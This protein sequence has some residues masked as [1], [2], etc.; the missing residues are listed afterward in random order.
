MVLKKIGSAIG[1]VLRIDSYPVSG[2][3]RSYA[4]LCIQVDLDKPLI[5]IVKIGRLR[6]KVMY[7]GISS[8]CFCCRCI[9]HKNENCCYEIQPKKV[10][11][12][13]EEIMP[14]SPKES[15]VEDMNKTIAILEKM[16]AQ[17]RVAPTDT[18]GWFKDELCATWKHIFPIMLSRNKTENL[19]LDHLAWGLT[20]DPRWKFLTDI[21]LITEK[22]LEELNKQR[23]PLIVPHLDKLGWLVQE[24][25]VIDFRG[26]VASHMGNMP[27]MKLF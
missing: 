23:R 2:S 20:L 9:G 4:R 6:Q 25:K 8:L 19:P 16:I 24:R 17:I 12:A 18:M 22:E 5:N 26:T 7:E 11:A 27:T 1:P 21:H 3:R 10:E 14:T 13:R 15:Q